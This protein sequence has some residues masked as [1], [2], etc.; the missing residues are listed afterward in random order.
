MATVAFDLN[1]TLL[2][3]TKLAEAL[4]GDTALVHRAV[5]A[6]VMHAMALSLAPAPYRPFKALVEAALRRE[7]ARAG[8][9]AGAADEAV[10]L[11]G[12]MPPFPDAVGALDTL[13]AAGHEL[14]VL[15]NSARSAAEEVLTTAGIRDRFAQVRGTDE[16]EAFKPSPEVYALVPE[17]GWLVAAHWWDILGAHHAGLRTAWVARKEQVLMPGVEADVT[18]PDLAAVAEAIVAQAG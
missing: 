5:E 13:A 3:T 11:L 6:A 15:T 7:L 16:V 10:A 4:E 14:I 1:G 17:G 18:G 2:D 12:S 8:R 9:D